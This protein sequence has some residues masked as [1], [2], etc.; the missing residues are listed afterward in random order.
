MSTITACWY[1]THLPSYTFYARHRLTLHRFFL[2]FLRH[3]VKEN[4]SRETFSQTVNI[5]RLIVNRLL[6]QTETELPDDSPMS[7]LMQHFFFQAP[8]HEIGKNDITTIPYTTCD[9]YSLS[10]LQAVSGHDYALV[11]RRWRHILIMTLWSGDN[12]AL[13]LSNS[14]FLP[15]SFSHTLSSSSYPFFFLTTVTG[16]CIRGCRLDRKS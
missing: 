6:T 7:I 8:W 13:P 9:I 12:I 5:F 2:Y 1:L 15:F 3:A 4:F 14:C 11:L 16:P 10:P